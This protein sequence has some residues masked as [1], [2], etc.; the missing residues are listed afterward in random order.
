MSTPTVDGENFEWAGAV[1]SNAGT[2]DAEIT[3][4]VS[5]TPALASVTG[6]TTGAVTVPA[7]AAQ[8]VGVGVGGFL[9]SA[10]VTYTLTLTVTHNGVDQS[11]TT[12]F[13]GD[14]P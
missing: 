9:V 2:T 7:G 4:V 10:G 14:V 3:W 6:P 12:T 8:P 1:V 13:S 11:A 5:V